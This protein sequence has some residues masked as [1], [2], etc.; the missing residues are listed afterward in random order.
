MKSIIFNSC[1]RQA[2]IE[3]S[4]LSFGVNA[5]I[6]QHDTKVHF[7]RSEYV[8][9]IVE[10]MGQDF[11]KSYHASIYNAGVPPGNVSSIN[12]KNFADVVS[13]VPCIP[14]ATVL[15]KSRLHHINFFIL[16]VEVR[17]S[18]LHGVSV[19]HIV[20]PPSLVMSGTPNLPQKVVVFNFAVFDCLTVSLFLYFDRFG[21]N[22]ARV[23]N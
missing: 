21:C 22:F 10:F 17:L 16:D 5:A 15:H 13:E 2:M 3:R 8:G 18:V 7:L 9:G 14:L 1:F 4:P 19:L 20:I 12:W 23:A 6:C 11:M